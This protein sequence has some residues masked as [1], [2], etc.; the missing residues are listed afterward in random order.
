M[1]A[2]LVGIIARAQQ[3]ALSL[4]L[5][6]GI[7]SAIAP[8]TFATTQQLTF[9]LN[10]VGN[11][12]FEDLM[13]EAESLTQATIEQTF[14]S[15]PETTQ[16]EVKVLGE[17]NGQEVPLLFTSVSRTGWQQEPRLQPWTRY[18]SR[19]SMTLLGFLQLQPNQPFTSTAS[20]V[21][22]TA[23]SRLEDTP[24]FRDD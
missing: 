14:A 20:F 2:G 15:S 21:S 9:T 3:M 19:A 13:Q 5:A 18:F 22:Q 17:R 24:G 12:R 1:T 7:C 11:Q 16:I 23:R 8:A 4:C 6:I 10:T